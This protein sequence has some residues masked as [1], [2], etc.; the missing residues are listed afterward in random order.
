MEE[1]VHRKLQVSLE[2]APEGAR[3][4]PAPTQTAL[5]LTAGSG[6]EFV[7]ARPGCCAVA[8]CLE[9]S[10]LGATRSMVQM[11]GDAMTMPF[12]KKMLRWARHPSCEDILARSRCWQFALS[13]S[14]GGL[15]CAKFNCKPPWQTSQGLLFFRRSDP[16]IQLRAGPRLHVS[17]QHRAVENEAQSMLSLRY[18]KAEID[19]ANAMVGEYGP[20]IKFEISCFKQFAVNRPGAV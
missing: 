16:T 1:R 5:H 8:L 3:S 6:P 15:S 17:W 9:A 20:K 13:R 14:C 19:L 11:E 2:E 10:V 4:L 18:F 12:L 7:P